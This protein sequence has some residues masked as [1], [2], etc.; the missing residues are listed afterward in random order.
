MGEVF[1]NISGSFHSTRVRKAAATHVYELF[2]V[3]YEMHA[4]KQT[5]KVQILVTQCKISLM[6]LIHTDDL[7]IKIQ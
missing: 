7:S 3:H 5:Y 6:Q 1:L 4:L 2:K